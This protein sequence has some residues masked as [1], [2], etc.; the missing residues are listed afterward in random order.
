MF[1]SINFGKNIY[2]TLR[3]FLLRI[4]YMLVPALVFFIVWTTMGASSVDMLAELKVHSFLVTIVL[5]FLAVLI[6]YI[7]FEV[8]LFFAKARL[9]YFNSLSEAL[10]IHKVLGDIKSIGV[11]NIIKW[12]VFMAI[13]VVV[14]SYVSSLVM[15]IPYVGFIIY[16]GIV[17]PILESIGNY[18]LG[19]LYSNIAE[20]ENSLDE[21]QKELD[22]LKYRELN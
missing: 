12:L 6:S 7:L 5:G 18:S 9:A 8:L 17:I 14:V 4:V 21:F 22:Y 15:L 1:P 10:K 13:L 20:K 2:D 3:L 19:L 11:V 16:L